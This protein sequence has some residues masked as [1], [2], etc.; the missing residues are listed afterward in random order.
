MYTRMKQQRPSCGPET[1]EIA[2]SCFEHW[3][4]LKYVIATASSP[5]VARDNWNQNTIILDGAREKSSHRWSNSGPAGGPETLQ[6]T[7]FQ[8][9]ILTKTNNITASRSPHRKQRT[10]GIAIPNHSARAIIVWMKK[11]RASRGIKDADIDWYSVRNT[12]NYQDHQ[13]RIK[14]HC[15]GW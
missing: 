9:G 2:V 5:S 1:N 8:F 12:D 4:G 14:P 13:D 6:S 10:I 11:Q 15:D 7:G 3:R